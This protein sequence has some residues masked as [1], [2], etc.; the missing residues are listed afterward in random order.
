MK[1]ISRVWTPTEIKLLSVV[2]ATSAIALMFA[3]CLRYTRKVREVEPEPDLMGEVA[4]N[5]L[6]LDT[7]LAEEINAQE[8]EETGLRCRSC[9][10]PLTVAGS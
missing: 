5:Q 4:K 3:P 6:K 9:S 8:Y 10:V 7:K 2:T 1:A